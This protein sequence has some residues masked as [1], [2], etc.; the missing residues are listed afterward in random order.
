M[1]NREE[2]PPMWDAEGANLEQAKPDETLR[3]KDP[4]PNEL[5]KIPSWD[6]DGV[7]LVQ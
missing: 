6:T 7:N 1:G 4:A 2:I 3:Q 5:W